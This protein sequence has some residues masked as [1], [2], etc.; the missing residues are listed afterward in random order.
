MSTHTH[1]L[2]DVSLE[3]V[4]LLQSRV[5]ILRQDGTGQLPPLGTHQV[6]VI[7][8]RLKDEREH[9]DYIAGTCTRG[10]DLT[11]AR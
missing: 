1:R 3:L 8:G 5:P 2:I 6:L 4:K 10:A 9:C 11:S 7:R